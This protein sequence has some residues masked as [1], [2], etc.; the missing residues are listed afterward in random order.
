CTNALLLDSKVFDRVPP[1]KRLTINVHLDGM[2]ETH[3]RV[4]AREGVFDKAVDMIR[5]A[6]L[7]GYR[8]M[9]NTTVYRDTPVEE[10]EALCD[11]VDGL[12]TDGMLVSPGYHY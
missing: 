10:I 2:R 9:T 1:N 7:R 11:F 6:K 4:C 5:A 12:G 8:V 3:D